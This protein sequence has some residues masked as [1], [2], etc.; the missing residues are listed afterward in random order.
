QHTIK[1]KVSVSGVGLHTGK[2]V[3]LT[4]NPAPENHWLKFQRI[5][6][7]GHP[8]IEADADLVVDTSRG[9]TLEKNGVKVATTEHVL[10]ALVGL[11][12]DNCLI[13]VDGP[14]M[15]I[16]DGSSWK[17]IEALEAAEI[18]EQEAFRNYFE[19]TE[20]LTYEDP[21]KKVEMLA[22]PQDTYR[23]TVMVD[24]NSE[25]LGTQHAGMYDIIQFKE[26]ISKCRTFVF[27]HELEALL[28]HN[29][30]KGGDLDNA[31]VLVDKELP[32]EKI[33]HLKKVFNKEHV[34]VKGRGVLNN[35][36][37]HFYNEPAR[38][39][40]LDII[41]DL[42]LVGKPLKIHVLAARPGHAGNVAFAKK[43]KEMMKKQK[44]ERMVPKIDLTAKP[45][46]DVTE[47]QKIL[48][49]RPPLLMVD[50]IMELTPEYIIGVK[51]VT[52]T[53]YWCTGHFPDEPIMPGVLIIEALAQTGGVLCLKTVPDPENY[54]T[55]F[56]KIESAKFKAKVVP[57]DTLVFR[58]DMVEPIRRGMCHMKG[59]AFVGNKVVCEADMTAQIVKVRG[60]D[61]KV[62]TEA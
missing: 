5:D 25:L 39:K 41:G 12:I 27:L 29:L 24:Y 7:E 10:A 4:F 50:K 57:G 22:V 43:I 30:I 19:L 52:M 2:K 48:P 59:M 21:I 15:P 9:T 44:N 54:Q 36:K 14:E 62:A 49:H 40:L 31:I 55:Y 46:C 34:E 37:L 11:Q 42:A 17:F 18:V 1:Q 20:N 60:I 35:T 6:V 56:L 16:M 38:H 45:V 3:T 33:D 13:Q 51:N 28:A 61:K 53:E 26:E 58:M 32:K 8:I 47:I 23:V